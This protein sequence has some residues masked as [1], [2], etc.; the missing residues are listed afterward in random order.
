MEVEIREMHQLAALSLDRL[1]DRRV[2]IAQRVD[3]DA[4]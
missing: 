3:S 1:I 4:G 2:S